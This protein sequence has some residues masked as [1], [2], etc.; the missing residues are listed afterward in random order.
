M[1]A[2]FKLF[3]PFTLL[4]ALFV[5]YLGQA[6]IDG[7]IEHLTFDE[8]AAV[9]L[10][11]GAMSGDLAVAAQH[12][13]GL[14][15]EKPITDTVETP[16]PVNLRRMVDSLT[17]L[18]LRNPGYDQV[19]WIDETGM[20]RVRVN[21]VDGNPVAVPQEA[22]Q[23]KA[24][25]YFFTD[26][27]GLKPGE[28]YLSPLDLNVEHG[29][30]E[31]PHRLMVRMA[32]PIMDGRGK[33]RGIL[34]INL[35]AKRL[36]EDFIQAADRAAPHML[37]L[38]H[39]GRWLYSPHLTDEGGFLLGDSDRF[40]SHF[41]DIWT[42][43]D[44]DASGHWL[45]DDGLWVWQDAAPRI[46]GIKVR[47]MTKEPP[48]KV[49]SHVPAEDIRAIRLTVWTQTLPVAGMLMAILA[50]ISGLSISREFRRE[51]AKPRLD[52]DE[53]EARL[54]WLAYAVAVVSPLLM[55]LLRQTLPASFGDRPML[56]LFVFPITLSAVLGGI[57]P[58]MV[59]TA[60][61]AL[62]ASYFLLAPIHSIEISSPY[63]HFQLMLLIGNGVLISVF[64]EI[65]IR[66]RRESER[67]RLQN[68]GIHQQL[69]ESDERFRQLAERTSDIFWMQEWPDKR[70]SYV[71]PAFETITGIPV[72]ALYQ[73]SQTWINAIHPDDRGGAGRAFEASVET[74]SLN[75]EYRFVR[76]DG[77]IRWVHDM[78]TPVRD[79]NGQVC[80]VVGIVRDITERKR[81]EEAL[82][83][84][85]RESRF[86]A[87]AQRENERRLHLFFE[88]APASLAMFDRD[89]RYLA[90]SRRWRKDY[91]LD[92]VDIIGRSHYEIFP[93][94]SDGW[95]NVHRRCLAGEV[96]RADEDRFT[97]K[98]GTEQWVRWEVRPWNRD[99]GS[100]GGIVIFTEDITGQ[101]LAAEA[102]RVAEERWQFAL[103]GSQQGVWDWDI[104]TGKI[105]FSPPWKALL[106]YAED[107]VSDQ[108]EEWS[109]RVHPDDL[110]AAMAAL[111]AHWRGETACYQNEH[112]LRN[113]AG[114]YQWT[115]AQGM[116]VSRDASGQPSRMIGTQ[117]DTREHHQLLQK[118]RDSEG[119]TRSIM[120]SLDSSIAVLDE[121]GTII[122]TNRAWRC[123]A[124]ENDGDDATRL[125]IG[126][127]YFDACK[128]AVDSPEALQTLEGM[129]L[130][131]N[132][133]Q[134]WFSLEYPC[135]VGDLKAWFQLQVL[136]LQGTMRGLVAYHVDITQ[137]KQTEAELDRHR[138]HLEEQ[139]A[140][141]TE[142]LE[143]AYHALEE[144]A[145]QIA[146]LYNN[147]PCGYHSLAADGTLLT[148]NDTE[149]AWLG[150]ARSEVEGHLHYDQLIAP[151]CLSIFRENFPKFKASPG[152]ILEVEIDLVCKDGS[153]L[154]VL[155]RATAIF[156]AEGRFVST[157]STLFDNRERK[158]KEAQIALL[159]AE[160]TRRADEAEASTRA[161]SSFLA[162]MSHEIRTPMNA[163][164]GFCYLLEQRPL[165]I[166]AL[167]LVRK[168]HNAGRSLL[169]LINDILD[170]SKIEAGH[171]E[172]ETVPF[173]LYG[174]LDDLAGIM[175]ASARDKNLEL[176]ITPP[177]DADALLGDRLRLQQVLVNL[178]GNAI[179]FTQ[180][181]EVELRISVESEDE[182]QL[183]LRFAVRDTGIGISPGQQAVIFSAFSQA[184]GTI[185]RRFGGTGLGLSISQQLVRLMGGNLQVHS[186]TGKGSE[187]WFV[188]PM[189]RDLLVK[190]A[191]SQ[192]SRLELLVADDSDAAREALSVAANSLGWKADVVDSGEA[193]LMQALARADGDGFYDALLL[194]WKMP[195]LDGLGAAEAIRKALET[196]KTAFTPSPII[197]MVT[198]YSHD[199]LQAQPGLV[200]V[201]R[202]MSKPV[203]PSTLY[204]TVADVLNQR[205]PRLFPAQT[206]PAAFNT[207]RI[208]GVRVLVVDDS[209]INLEVAQGILQGDG[210]IVY[211]AG[212]GQ[213]AVDWLQANPDAV[214][215]VL[216][217]VQMP[218][219]D[220][221]AATRRIRE[222][223][224]W[225]NLP[226][227][228]LTA[229]AFDALRDAAIESGMNDFLAKPFNVGQM[230]A[231]IQRWTGCKP[232]AKAAMRIPTAN[233][234][235]P[236][237]PQPEPE[238][239]PP[240]SNLPGIDLEKGLKLWVKPEKYRTYLNKFVGS[241]A[242]AG[243]D[244]A[245]YC[246]Q[247]DIS[248]AAALAHKLLGVAGSMA[249][250]RVEERV[251]PLDAQLKTG[252]PDLALAAELQT[253]LDEVCASVAEWMATETPEPAA[254]P[255][256]AIIN[257]DALAVLLNQ[258]LDALD[259]SNPNSAE[260][261]LVQMQGQ[262]DSTRL[263]EIQA[264]LNDFDFQAAEILA[265]SL[266][267]DL[268]IT[269]NR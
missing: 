118:L 170:F 169:A 209:D 226:I 76:P 164:L 167:V 132:S 242:S 134:A 110:E 206:Q 96:I 89:M 166:E 165:D 184:D 58:G 84:S 92:S 100:T 190:H 65:L 180:Q 145:A 33:P 155:V 75:I 85:E 211:L 220:G 112:R 256:D 109:G 43:I 231:L 17:S 232:E 54:G 128:N 228:A 78:G 102:L 131:L 124:T 175:V 94:I 14:I 196:R 13:L 18:I 3:L 152:Y 182:Q 82:S 27:M 77:S 177:L 24:D 147:A 263:A 99:D 243:Q 29:Q 205:N 122:A 253:A 23:S 233:P 153:L 239:A 9:R 34:I 66:A 5:G 90:V 50:F 207:R 83:A 25:R 213:E 229:G 178:L 186:E 264:R 247:N 266:M 162:N 223:A 194:D 133:G 119:L 236:L 154:P 45:A 123:F 141:R 30:I 105:Y 130:V 261:V 70:V 254:K 97:R 212:D 250:P 135:D 218:L 48:W 55:L 249:L 202:V 73:D 199:D 216:M 103:E 11:A 95:K 210:A 10:G 129:R 56:L 201:D 174:L 204:N 168:V 80:R 136:P 262:V 160:L 52:D 269:M 140:Q 222:E 259:Y 36:F 98:D 22:L 16:S 8:K 106:G 137:R 121:E 183:N 125:G 26:T 181:G 195:G 219:M 193:A 148:I 21:N 171:L 107:E 61:A 62:C 68:E 117:L 173:S 200:W 234:S 37:L 191:P 39:Q 258:L 88:Y 158:A 53:A 93:E 230:M 208:P 67:R 44:A 113:R 246:R 187:F 257:R 6:R 235:V 115:L 108:I 157:R 111:Q 237:T 255:V 185:S 161:K 116:V 47:V 214:D 150:Y 60:L 244:I 142:L 225:K 149:L 51:P 151:H 126:Q 224:R 221:Y 267:N 179:K 49:V 248:A 69:R 227:V 241:Y 81:I 268:N 265:T 203:T 74:N 138:H 245:A 172:I 144:R 72:E 251:Q 71:S 159:N 4:G 176:V 79:P 12:L 40:G 19:R 156:D 63:D 86:M 252:Q 15:R 20:E 28:V 189:R 57:G 127:N 188:L 198:A 1:K 104:A 32:T 2:W 31:V 163:V 46:A 35:L 38:N 114:E 217:D 64:S 143:Y 59:A 42:R 7:E 91:S 215:I 197:I 41:P 120:D 139:V 260:S 192:L 87:E 146:D 240:V 238:T 101:R